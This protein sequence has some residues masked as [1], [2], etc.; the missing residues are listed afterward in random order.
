MKNKVFINSVTLKLSKKATLNTSYGAIR[1]TLHSRKIEKPT[2]SD[3]SKAVIAIRQSKLPDPA[4]IG[5]AGSFFKNPVVTLEHFRKLKEKWT[6]LPG[7]A[8]NDQIKVPAAWLIE[9]CGWK[10]KRFGDIGVHEK[11]A[12]VLVN[13]G[14]G[15]GAAIEELALKIQASVNDTFKVDLTPR[16]QY[17]LA[18]INASRNNRHHLPQK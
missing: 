8:D 14:D 18:E 16:S 2:A 13:Y 1:D 6:G 4:E 3:I 5:N 10:G 9:N 11:Q 12:L 17:H 15:D 7:Y